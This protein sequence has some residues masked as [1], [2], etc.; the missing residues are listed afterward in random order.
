M[1]KDD[2]AGAQPLFERALKGFERVLG[3]E[4]PSTLMSMNNLAGLLMRKGDYVGAQPLFERALEV[5]EQILGPASRYA[6]ERVQPGH[7]AC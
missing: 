1:S 7:I 6:G 3:P 2:Y 4:H 5:H